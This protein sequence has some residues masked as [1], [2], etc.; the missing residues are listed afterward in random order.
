MTA[1]FLANQSSNLQNINL[2]IIPEVE[3]ADPVLALSS[4]EAE[5]E[6]VADDTPEDDPIPEKT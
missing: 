2:Y 3:L 6:E 1:I 4:D 5:D